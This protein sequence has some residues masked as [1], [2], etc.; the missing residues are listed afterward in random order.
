MTNGMTDKEAVLELCLRNALRYA[1]GEMKYTRDLHAQM[2]Y[3]YKH[4]RPST[5]ALL[6][7]IFGLAEFE[8]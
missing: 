4:S 1:Q 5:K 8:E 2:Q 3:A 6:K 7:T